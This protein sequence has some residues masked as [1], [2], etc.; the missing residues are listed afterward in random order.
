V[1]TE[2][3]SLTDRVSLPWAGDA[4]RLPRAGKAQEAIAPIDRYIEAVPWQDLGYMVRAEAY[5]AVGQS[6]RAA[7]D[8]IKAAEISGMAEWMRG[9]M[10]AAGVLK[11][12]GQES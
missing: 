7:A 8:F 1:V 3:K 2:A 5:Q 10:I 9:P 11:T 12:L 4:I 6:D